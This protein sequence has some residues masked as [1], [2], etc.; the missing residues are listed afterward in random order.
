MRFVPLKLAC[1]LAKVESVKTKL[2][3]TSIQKPWND[4]IPLFFFVFFLPTNVLV[5][6]MVSKW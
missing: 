6:T 4:P 5:S 2:V 1:F 3:R